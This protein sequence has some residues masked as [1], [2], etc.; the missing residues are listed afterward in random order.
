[1]LDRDYA[2]P[3]V[4]TDV[5]ANR[6]NVHGSFDDIDLFTHPG[7]VLVPTYYGRGN[8]NEL[9][10]DALTLGLL[11]AGTNDT[12]RFSLDR[13]GSSEVYDVALQ[14]SGCCNDDRWFASFAFNNIPYQLPDASAPPGAV[15]FTLTVDIIGSSPDF[16]IPS[17][18]NAG[19]S[20]DSYTYSFYVV[21]P[22]PEPAT[23]VLLGLG[24]SGIV[25][26]PL[27]RSRS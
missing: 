4:F 27:R 8:D 24:L 14:Y 15:L 7:A 21:K 22:I 2:D 23:I 17:G 11:P 16:V 12:L 26:I 18:P 20:V 10:F 13:G 19:E 9:V 5:N 6:L 3:L 1:M 25:S